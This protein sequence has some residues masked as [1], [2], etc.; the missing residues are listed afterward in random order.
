MLY[1]QGFIYSFRIKE[2]QDCCGRLG[3]PKSGRKADLRDRLA[4][5]FKDAYEL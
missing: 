2:L 1:M 5:I 4:N 3:L